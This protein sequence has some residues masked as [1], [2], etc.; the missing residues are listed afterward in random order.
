MSRAIISGLEMSV[1]HRTILPSTVGPPGLLQHSLSPTLKRRGFRRQDK[2]QSELNEMGYVTIL[3]LFNELGF[4]TRASRHEFIFRLQP[5]QTMREFVGPLDP[6][7]K[8]APVGMP[9]LTSPLA[10]KSCQ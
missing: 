6:T 3:T 8:P 2:E 5:C 9:Q 4:Y 1:R 10:V 7:R